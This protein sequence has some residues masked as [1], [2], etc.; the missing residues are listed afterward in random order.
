MR[1]FST[2]NFLH[3]GLKIKGYGSVVSLAGVGPLTLQAQRLQLSIRRADAA[4][5]VAVEALVRRRL[6][7][8]APSTISSG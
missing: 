1:T 4:F 6:R 2:R 8:Y 3:S 5:R 7:V